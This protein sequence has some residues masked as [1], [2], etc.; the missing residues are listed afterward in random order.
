ME[1]I[2]QFEITVPEAAVDANRHVNN[3]AYV[4]WMQEAAIRHSE[5]A[6]CTRETLAA[7]ATWV[8]RTHRIEYL[9]PA[10]GGERLRV[11]TWVAD[12]RRCVRCAATSSSA[13]PMARCW[14]KGK[15]IGYL[16]MP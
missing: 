7:G 2:Y 12:V 10:F 4:Q 1:A 15:P 16:S 8:V 5:A 13:R 11:Q 6:G 14:Q 9:S 3:V